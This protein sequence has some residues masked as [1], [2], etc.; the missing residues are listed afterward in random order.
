MTSVTVAIPTYRRNGHLAELIP[1][2]LEQMDEVQRDGHGAQLL[3]VD[4]DPDGGAGT[5]VERVG[6]RRIVYAHETTPGLAAVRNRA[7]DESTSELLAFMDDDGR[8]APGWLRR[9]VATWGRERCAAVAGRVLE[10]YEREP[11]SWIVAGRFFRRRSL[12]TGTV[13]T[14]APAGNLLLDLTEIRRLGLRFD[15]RFGFSGGEDTLFTRQ[16]TAAGGRI[17][18][19]DEARVVDQVPAERISRAWVLQRARNQGNATVRVEVALATGAAGRRRARVT[20]L[21]GGIARSIAGGARWVLGQ[22][23]RSQA[24]QALGLRTACKGVGMVSGA[25]GHVERGY[26]R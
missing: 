10:Q 5:V 8:P 17:V 20:S 16:L 14:A 7:L 18:W 9:L 1:L 11:D 6:D 25:V 23:S 19:C 15:P 4:N 26:R 22:V 2:L 12:P 24:H 21:V 3:L 13:V